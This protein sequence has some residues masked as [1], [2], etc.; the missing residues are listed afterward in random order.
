[1]KDLNFSHNAFKMLGFVCSFL[2][3]NLLF[4]LIVLLLLGLLC[5]I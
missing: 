3:F 2:I 4:C 1:M 5:G